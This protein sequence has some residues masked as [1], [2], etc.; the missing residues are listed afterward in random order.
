MFSHVLLSSIRIT[1]LILYYAM[2]YAL[3]THMCFLSSVIMKEDTIASSGVA[4]LRDNGEL[5][6]LKCTSGMGCTILQ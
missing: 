3:F 6:E 5:L 2:V 4:L 1:G